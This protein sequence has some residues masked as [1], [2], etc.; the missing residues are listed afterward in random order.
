MPKQKNIDTVATLSEK[1]ARAKSL[2]LTDYRGLTHKQAEELHKAL[3]K[4]E[5]EY[6]VAKNSLL[7][8]ASNAGSHK[9]TPE[10][11]IGPTG[12]LLSYGDEIAPLKELYKT[13]KALTLPKVKFGFISGKRYD[14]T[15]VETIAKLPTKEV[16]QAQVVGRLNGPI[17]GLVY[18]LNYN[19][20]KLVYVLGQ[21]RTSR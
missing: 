17:Y 21:I 16:L 15:E 9:V 12:A 7:S 3:K 8:I 11:L 5:A 4:V 20:Q 2:I 19:L 10:D 18:D 14:A 6:V 1:L 13:I